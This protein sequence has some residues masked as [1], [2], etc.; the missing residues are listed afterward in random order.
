MGLK[1]TTD[2]KP[3]TVV[4][5]DKTSSQG[6]A[7]TQYSVMISSKNTDGTWV[8]DFIDCDGAA[9]TDTAQFLGIP[10]AYWGIFFYI[11]VLFLTFVDKLKNIK[12][13]KFLEVFKNPLAYIAC[14]GLISFI[15]SMVLASISLFVIHKLCILCVLTYFIDLIISLFAVDFKV[16]NF[17]DAIKTTFVDFVDGA[18]KYFKTFLV[19]LLLFVSFLTYSGMTLNFVPHVKQHKEILKYNKTD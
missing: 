4:R 9:K 13:F 1:I 10:L 8:N 11:V 14:L 19:L 17:L 15:V 6:N 16:K 3:V 2:G 12:L 5:Q 7:Y 18:K